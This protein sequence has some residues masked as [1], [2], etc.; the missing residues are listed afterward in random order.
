MKPE[1]D[2][3]RTGETRFAFSRARE[4]KLHKVEGGVEGMERARE[5]GRAGCPHSHMGPA[6][7]GPDLQ[8]SS[9]Q[10]A[11]QR[12]EPSVLN[13]LHA[14]GSSSQTEYG[15]MPSHPLGLLLCIFQCGS[16]HAVSYRGLRDEATEQSLQNQKLFYMLSASGQVRRSVTE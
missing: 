12:E 13:A 10:I 14:G 15:V 7:T 4:E 16:E 9:G 5:R 6:T 1:P 2:R 11:S 3:R 8:P